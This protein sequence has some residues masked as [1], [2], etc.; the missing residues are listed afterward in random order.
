MGQYKRASVIAL[1]LSLWCSFASAA[2]KGKVQSVDGKPIAN[3]KVICLLYEGE[4]KKRKFVT[5]TDT[6]GNFVFPEAEITT[7]GYGASLYALAEGYGVGGCYIRSKNPKIR[8]SSDT[9]PP[10]EPVTIT[11]FPE[12]VLEFRLVDE[13][14]KPVQGAKVTVATVVLPQLYNVRGFFELA[15]PT[16]LTV[17]EEAN[18]LGL[19]ATSDA[20]GFVRLRNLPMGGSVRLWIEHE[21]FG[22]IVTPTGVSESEIRLSRTPLTVLQD[23]VLEEPGEAE[24][25]VRYEDGSPAANVRLFWRNPSGWISGEVT[26]DENGRYRLSK[27]QPC[28]YEI[29]LHYKEPKASEWI[30][31][32]PFVNFSVQSGQKI[33]LPTIT[34][35]KGGFLEGIVKDIETG[36]P[37]ADVDISVGQVFERADAPVLN[38]VAHAKTDKQGRYRV[39]V[40]PGE[41]ECY[42][43]SPPPPYLPPVE[44]L[45]TAPNPYKGVIKKGE[46]IRMDFHLRK[47][48]MVRGH[49]VD[50]RGKPV[51]NAVVLNIES[52]FEP[53]RTVADEKGNFVLTNLQP[54][55]QVRLRAYKDDLSTKTELVFFPDEP[56]AQNI[57]LRLEKVSPPKVK[58]RVVDE[59]GN[60]IPHAIITVGVTRQ[61]GGMMV[62]WSKPVA[63]TD[64]QGNFEI[65][66][67]W[68]GDNYSITA[69][70]DGYSEGYTGMFTLNLNEVRDIGT[71]TLKRAG[72]VLKGIVM[73]DE[74]PL[75]NV[76]VYTVGI[77][78]NATRTD[79]NGRFELRGLASGQCSLVVREP[80]RYGWLNLKIEVGESEGELK[81]LSVDP[82]RA[83]LRR[84]EVRNGELVIF[85]RP[86]TPKTEPQDE[87]TRE[88][89]SRL[90]EVGKLAPDFS[91][92]T[93]FNTKPLTLSALRGKIVVINF[94][95]WLG[96]GPCLQE[97]PSVVRLGQKFSKK[98]VVLVSIHSPAWETKRVQQFI[99]ERGLSH[100][101]AIDRPVS[102]YM[103]ETM[104]RY[105]VRSLPTYAVIDRQG[106][107]KYLGES[108]NEVLN[109]VERL[110]GRQ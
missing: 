85:L 97:L 4:N 91:V 49:V 53:Q 9:L 33:V 41:F 2:I 24:G 76:S 67:L 83:N 65:S 68:H 47:G 110:V 48:L 18:E 25:E 57:V 8:F 69:H 89:E 54:L 42:I 43:F 10:D 56:Q 82:L 52:A 75:Q 51:P 58:G 87:Q 79:R 27:L 88:I 11:L 36:E 59:A 29:K 20:D 37:I 3:A 12:T 46:T 19:I 90:P 14:G 106:V 78:M 62:G 16:W 71:I 84:V 77:G 104:M 50:E 30:A 45:P 74:G 55:K 44:F 81:I 5:R 92:Q 39:Q 72:I 17:S 98:G 108:L 32:P 63:I 73:G 35:G 95:D 26:T 6:R 100:P 31:L 60:P 15:L 86:M 96:C 38:W 28:H 102:Q 7:E 80:M 105:G 93:W 99:K 94:C 61:Y 70:A 34:L 103:G 21:R 109:W 107:L 1:T 13:D 64:A 101:I 66:G 22:R 40:P 23:I